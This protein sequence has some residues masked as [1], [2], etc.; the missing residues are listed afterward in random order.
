MSR[1][2]F[3][4][5]SDL[6]IRKNFELQRMLTL[7]EKIVKFVYIKIKNICSFSDLCKEASH[8][9]RENICNT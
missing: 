5:L 8:K 4:R 1:R 2:K 7:K 9:V 3:R 6:G